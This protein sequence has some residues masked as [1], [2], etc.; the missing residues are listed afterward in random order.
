MASPVQPSVTN[1]SSFFARTRQVAAAMVVGATL[2]GS[3]LEEAWPNFLNPDIVSQFSL[4]PQDVAWLAA[5]PDLCLIPVPLL[6]WFWE[7]LL[8]PGHVIH[9]SLLPQ[10]ALWLLIAFL[11]SRTT[12]FIA[13]TCI[14]IIE[15]NAKSIVHVH[16]AEL[17][18]AK[19]RGMLTIQSGVMEGVGMLTVYVISKYLSWTNAHIVCSALIGTVFIF[20]T[21]VPESP[22]WLL[23]KGKI[24]EAYQALLRLRGNKDEV[25]LE[26][27]EIKEA[28]SEK[29]INTI[30]DQV[31]QLLIPMNYKPVLLVST[32]AFLQAAG[33]T[34]I[35][36]RFL[37]FLLGEGNPDQDPAFQSIIIGVAQLVSI[38][39]SIF[40]IDRVERRTLIVGSS[41][42]C[43]V[44][45]ACITCVL[46]L[47]TAPK[48]LMGVFLATFTVFSSFGIDPVVNLVEAEVLPIPVRSVGARIATMVFSLSQFLLTVTYGATSQNMQ[49]LFLSF[50]VSNLL[51]GLVSWR[52]I[53]GTKGKPLTKLQTLFRRRS[54]AAEK[55]VN[56]TCG[57]LE[58]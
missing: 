1:P 11:P 23:K 58:K 4:Q 38:C 2:V 19:P 37:V 45:M 9:L 40:F 18:R 31:S 17:V 15:A 5:I 10:I 51:L 36:F 13:C 28:I 35:V 27:Q 33:G 54:R 34:N 55:N 43:A 52:W 48:W 41:L 50:T 22:Y 14:S 42:V 16:I 44:S 8:G 26:L 30:K 47:S 24:D 49:V 20:M 56:R 32:M 21:F 25:D 6:A 7:D 46:H 29:P 39:A 12:L 57:T 53:P 3:G